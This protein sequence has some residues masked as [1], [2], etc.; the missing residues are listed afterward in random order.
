MGRRFVRLGADDETAA[1]LTSALARLRGP[2]ATAALVGVMTAPNVAAR[3]AAAS[4]LA[5]LA[6]REAVA[7]LQRGAREDPER[8][9][10]QI[11]S[12]LVAR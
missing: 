10:R 12:L 7:V 1:V 8:E 5:A 6:T 3:K 9:V 11:C 2:N 4:V